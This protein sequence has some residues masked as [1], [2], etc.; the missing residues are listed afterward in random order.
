LFVLVAD[1]FSILAASLILQSGLMNLQ[2]T[3]LVFGIIQVI[4]G[5]IWLKSVVP[6]E[7]ATQSENNSKRTP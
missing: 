6:A 3:V 1:S 5:L 4:T 7:R 2:N